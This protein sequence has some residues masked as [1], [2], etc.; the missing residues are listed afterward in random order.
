MFTEALV[1]GAVVMVYNVWLMIRGRHA[2]RTGKCAVRAPHDTT[3]CTT[4][5]LNGGVR[6]DFRHL[7]GLPSGAG[8]EQ[9]CGLCRRCWGLCRFCEAYVVLCRQTTSLTSLSL[10]LTEM[11]IG[12]ET[13]RCLGAFS[14]SLLQHLTLDLGCTDIVDEGAACRF[15]LAWARG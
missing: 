9:V 14:D 15:R 6:S 5:L 12:M 11:P 13:M 8:L 7:Q 4:D 10:H 2:L 1:C 3:N